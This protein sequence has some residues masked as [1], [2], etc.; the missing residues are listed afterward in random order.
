MLR[1]VQQP[2]QQVIEQSRNELAPTIKKE[3]PKGPPF[4]NNPLLR[5]RS[6]HDSADESE[7]CERLNDT[8]S[9]EAHTENGRFL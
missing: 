1:R 9:R 3:G 6:H 7:K 5:L 4:K 2:M 8:G